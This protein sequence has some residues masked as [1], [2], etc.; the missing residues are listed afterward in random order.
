MFGGQPIS[1]HLGMFACAPRT[2]HSRVVAV[3]N[4]EPPRSK[5]VLG[6]D[7][8]DGERRLHLAGSLSIR[9][10]HWNYRMSARCQSLCRPRTLRRS[11]VRKTYLQRPLC[12]RSEDMGSSTAPCLL[13][14]SGKWFREASFT[15]PSLGKSDRPLLGDNRHGYRQISS[16]RRKRPSKLSHSDE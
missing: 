1:A 15:L 12:V 6:F 14:R 2:R 8:H 4:V 7:L 3:D 9:S 13:G 10:V 5:A 16:H 11:S